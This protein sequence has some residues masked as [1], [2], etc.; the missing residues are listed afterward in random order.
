MRPSIARKR[1]REDEISIDETRSRLNAIASSHFKVAAASQGRKTT[2]ATDQFDEDN[3]DDLV[4]YEDV[5]IAKKTEKGRT[6]YE[7]DINDDDDDDDIEDDRDGKGNRGQDDSDGDINTRSSTI[8]E[9]I[10]R[11]IR[12]EDEGPT[13]EAEQGITLE[14]FNLKEAREEGYYNASGDFVY[15]KSSK[16]KDEDDDEDDADEGKDAWLDELDEMD[17]ALRR[18]LQAEVE[19]AHKKRLEREGGKSSITAGKGGKEHNYNDN[20]DDIDGVSKKD[21]LFGDGESDVSASPQ[22]RCQYLQILCD[23]LLDGESAA[24]ALRRLGAGAKKRSWQK[25]DDSTPKQTPEDLLSFNALTD[26]LDGLVN[27][28]LV[29][30]YSLTR[31]LAKSELRQTQAE[32]RE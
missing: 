31:A 24:A 12:G 22:V 5:Q 28:G 3:G 9:K 18:K 25:V 27:D 8:R 16:D 26:A 1:E 2:T 21:A 7:D 10:I 19:L 4:E 20:N 11:K 13:I 30:A 6:A 23:T 14:P 17:P 29:D 32:M 15:N